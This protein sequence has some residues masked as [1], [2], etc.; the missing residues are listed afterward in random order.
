MTPFILMRSLNQVCVMYEAEF[1]IRI[2]EDLTKQ[3]SSAPVLTL[4]R[5]N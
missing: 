3:F 4:Q 1:G 5:R 2:G